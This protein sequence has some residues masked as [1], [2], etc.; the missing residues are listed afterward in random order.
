MRHRLRSQ[1]SLLVLPSRDRGVGRTDFTLQVFAPAGSAV[2]LDRIDRPL[3]FSH[4]VEGTITTKTAGGHSGWPSYGVNPQFR[5]D[6]GS[7]AGSEKAELRVE[8][9][10][11]AEVPWNVKVL[12]SAGRVV[13]E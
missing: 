11:D 3:A 6:L 5:L 7:S 9:R 8:L 10:G 12:W 4:A 13:H 2:S 1:T